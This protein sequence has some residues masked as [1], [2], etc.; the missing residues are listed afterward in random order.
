MCGLYF[1]FFINFV[2]FWS[3]FILDCKIG[4]DDIKVLILCFFI[5]YFFFFNIFKVFL[6]VVLFILK[7]FVS[8][9]LEGSLLFFLNFFLMSCFNF[10]NI[11][12]YFWGYF[13]DLKFFIVCIC[14]FFLF[15]RLVRNIVG[16]RCNVFVI[17][18]N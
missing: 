17:Y 7:N 15:F 12:L 16:S 4:C 13:I 10:F 14:F 1:C 6:S 3:F 18:F 8:F 11:S 9:S 2:I 5:I